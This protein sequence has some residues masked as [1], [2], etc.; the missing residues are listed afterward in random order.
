MR[1]K[2][3]LRSALTRL[4]VAT[5]ALAAGNPGQ[6]AVRTWAYYFPYGGQTV[7]GTWAEVKTFSEAATNA[8]YGNTACVWASPEPVAELDFNGQWG[9]GCT[10]TFLVPE[11]VTLGR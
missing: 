3:Q 7:V 9:G 10:G 5:G 8:Y 4:L 1:C 6:A 2:H 11:S